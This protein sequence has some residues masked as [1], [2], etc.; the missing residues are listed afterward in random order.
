MKTQENRNPTVKQWLTIGGIALV[1]I[2]AVVMILIK[3]P[4]EP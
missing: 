2:L 1:L 4:Q 3:I